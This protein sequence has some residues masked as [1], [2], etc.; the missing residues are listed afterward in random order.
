MVFAQIREAKPSVIDQSKEEA[1]KAREARKKSG[2]REEVVHLLH[3]AI[4]KN[5][6]PWN[7][8]FV[9]DE[10]GVIFVETAGQRVIERTANRSRRHFI[11]RA[12]E[13]FHAGSIGRYDADERKILCL[14]RQC[15]VI[16]D[17]VVVRE[18]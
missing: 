4:G 16:G 1:L 3:V 13:Q 5:V 8:N 12:A 18:R 7:E 2:S 9:E 11:G 6:F 15:S 10:D 14:D 17:E